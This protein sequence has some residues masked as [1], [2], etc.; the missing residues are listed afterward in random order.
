MPPLYVIPGLGTDTRIYSQWKTLPF[1][2]VEWIE[3]MKDESLREYAKRMAQA[4]QHPR[5]I[6]IGVSFGG[7]LAQEIASFLPVKGIILISSIKSEQELPHSLRLMRYVPFYQLS[8][9]QWRVRTLPL[10]GRLFGIH[11]KEERTL[12]MDMFQKQTDSYRMWAIRNLVHWQASPLKVPLIHIHGTKDRVFPFERILSCIP[13]EGGDHFMVYRKAD[14]V[15]AIVKRSLV[16]K[17][18][19][20]GQL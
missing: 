11:E 6:L 17:I 3:P 2:G 18:L 8:R 14:E 1:I 4:I 12:L 20:G 16:G 9:G 13:V 10:W 7:V 5:P 15:E 19:G